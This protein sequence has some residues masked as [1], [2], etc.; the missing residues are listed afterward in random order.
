MLD[1]PPSPPR[2]PLR[3]RLT[4]AL[5]QFELAAADK[6]ERVACLEARKHFAWY[7]RGVP[8]ANYYKE[9]V[10][11]VTTLDEVRAV[12]EGAM[13]DLRDAEDR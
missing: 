1:G 7:L 2:P 3:E 13:R 4:T 5:R 8:Y 11:S 12:C 9:K 6:G 10:S